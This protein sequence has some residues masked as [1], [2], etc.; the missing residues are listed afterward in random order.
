MTALLGIGIGAPG[1]AGEPSRYRTRPDLCGSFGHPPCTY[2]PW[3][4]KTWCLCG[5]TVAD[6]NAVTVPH[7]AGCD[8]VLIEAVTT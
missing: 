6:G 5:R 3:L 1:L 4:D 7:V 8:G 2:N